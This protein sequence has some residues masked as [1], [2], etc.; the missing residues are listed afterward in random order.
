ML[1]SCAMPK[2]PHTEQNSEHSSARDDRCHVG[3]Y[4]DHC[5]RPVHRTSGCRREA[6]MP[7][8]LPRP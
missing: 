7:H 4:G 1:D 6:C 3:P 8:A 5:L 2:N